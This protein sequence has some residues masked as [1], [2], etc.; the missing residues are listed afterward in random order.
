MAKM[1]SVLLWFLGLGS[2]SGTQFQNAQ[3]LSKHFS[4]HAAEWGEKFKNS[5]Q[6]LDAARRLLNTKAGGKIHEFIGKQGWFFKYNSATNEF[7]LVSNKG[8]LSTFFKPR[9]GIAYWY[10]QIRKHK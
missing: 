9:E 6:Y 1:P 2:F 10:D 5:Q 4:D 8:T 3:H 7:V